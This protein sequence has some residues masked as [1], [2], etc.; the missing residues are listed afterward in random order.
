MFFRLHRGAEQCAFYPARTWPDAGSVNITTN[1]LVSIILDSTT[2]AGLAFLRDDSFT[3]A[4]F[5]AGALQG[6]LFYSE[7]TNPPT[8]EGGFFMRG[9]NYLGADTFNIDSREGILSWI[10]AGPFRLGKHLR[11]TEQAAHPSVA[12][13]GIATQG[14]LY[15]MDDG[16]ETAL[17]FESD[18]EGHYKLV[19]LGGSGAGHDIEYLEAPVGPKTIINFDG[20]IRADVDGTRID[21]TL[22]ATQNVNLGFSGGGIFTFGI[23]D[24]AASNYVDLQG[25]NDT[26]YQQPNPLSGSFKFVSRSKTATHYSFETEGALGEDVFEI[27]DAPFSNRCFYI[28]EFGTPWISKNNTVGYVWTNTL[29][30]VATVGEIEPEVTTD[31]PSTWGVGDYFGQ[32]KIFDRNPGHTAYMYLE[33]TGALGVAWVQFVKAR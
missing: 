14:R 31:D 22:D 6:G 27:T 19:G 8:A 29:E 17:W 2:Q 10:D 18:I 26:V 28:D 25:V 21:V 3:Q 20:G 33:Q 32:V 1:A 13:A 12:T 11:L 16:G 30:E 4:T 7:A 5:T 9:K 23:F 15:T 24:D